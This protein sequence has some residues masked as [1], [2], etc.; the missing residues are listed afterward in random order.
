MGR[1]RL[2]TAQKAKT[3]D[4]GPKVE[5]RRWLRRCVGSQQSEAAHTR[6]GPRPPGESDK[7]LLCLCF[8]NRTDAFTVGCAGAS[9]ATLAGSSPAAASQAPLHC[10]AQALHCGGVSGCRAWALG[11]MGFG[12]CARRALKS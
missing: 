6:A 1:Q 2:R 11:R 3:K 4:K 8:D 12:G 7:G 9:T 5:A 10:G